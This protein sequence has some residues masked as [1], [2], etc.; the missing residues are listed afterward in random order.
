LSVTIGALAGRWVAMV[1]LARSGLG[2]SAF[3][4]ATAVLGTAATVAGAL[5]GRD[6][7]LAC[8]RC[9]ARVCLA[10]AGCRLRVEGLAR[11][12]LGRHYVVMSNHQSALDPLV[13]LA[14]LPTPLRCAFWVKR[15]LFR[16]PFLGA[17]MRAMGF[18]PVDRVDRSG[19]GRM[20]A[21]SRRLVGEGRSVLVFPEETYGPG[22]ALLPFQRGG[23][24]LALK[25]RLPILPVGIR[26]TRAALAPRAN[27]IVPAALVVRFGAPVETAGEG[28]SARDRLV[29]Q[30]RQAISGLCRE[31]DAA[32]SG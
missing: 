5:G 27:F 3:G 23:F 18:V 29:E 22:D 10:A 16:A 21:S 31:Q 30:T 12:D 9:W 20:L 19:A 17:A 2:W 32:A 26:G 15:S 14:A 28:V 13:L 11:V 24:L 8:A 7:A 1:R 25:E 6:L 4:L